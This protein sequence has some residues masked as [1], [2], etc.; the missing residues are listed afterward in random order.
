MDHDSPRPSVVLRRLVNGYQVTQAIHVAAV[1]GIADLLADGP[2]TSDELAVAT[3]SHPETLYRLLRALASVG[4]FRE[5]EARRFALTDLGACLRSDAPE[6]IGGWAVFVGE[7]LV[8]DDLE[9]AGLVLVAAEDALFL[10]RAD[11][12]EDGHLA[13][14][15]L[16][17]ELLHGGRVA[18]EVTVITDGDEHVELPGSEI[19]GS[20]FPS[21]S[22]RG[23]CAV[24]SPSFLSCGA[25]SR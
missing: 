13:G 3:T 8:G 11:V 18:V 23:R 22:W 4:V 6:P 16:I 12:F 10:E 24:W 19:H 17:G 1:L 15:E 7:A 25:L 21:S 2:R 20:S 14:A 9:G 5:E